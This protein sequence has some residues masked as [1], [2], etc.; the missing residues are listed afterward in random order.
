M[1][2]DL[3]GMR[4]AVDGGMLFCGVTE[5]QYA[6]NGQTYQW[7]AGVT[8]KWSLSFS[9]LGDLDEGALK[10][11]FRAALAEI[12]AAC[13]IRHEYTA[14]ARNANILCQ[15]QRLDG[16]GG[17]LADMQIPSVGA[18][19]DALTLM[20]RFDDGEVWGVW[21][22]PP[23]G[24]IDLYRVALHELLHAHGL[25]HR[26]ANINE[27]AIIAP[28]YSTT[29]RHLQPAD[30]AELVR[31][32]GPPAVVTVPPPAPS[33]P[34]VP[35]GQKPDVAIAVTIAGERWIADGTLRKLS[36]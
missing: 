18:H 3:Y 25:G 33:P 7:P 29:I 36:P 4:S 32:Y 26:P 17:T 34:A 27:P 13:N 30:K 19:P 1:D 35:A 12:A 5:E 24:K 10:E 16:R 15:V 11:V 8:L 2:T 21:E 14:N 9:K 28:I 22:N 31:R 23:P 6:I 20:G